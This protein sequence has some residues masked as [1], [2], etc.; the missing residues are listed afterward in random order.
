MGESLILPNVQHLRISKPKEYTSKIVNN[1]MSGS[2][3]EKEQ[4]GKHFFTK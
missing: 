4:R 3:A 1:L 2:Q